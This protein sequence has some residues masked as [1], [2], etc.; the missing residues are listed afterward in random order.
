MAEKQEQCCGTCRHALPPPIRN[1]LG[2]DAT[3]RYPV[4]TN[5]LPSAYLQSWPTVMNYHGT[6]CPTY[7]AKESK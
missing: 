4:D 1:G 6:Y 7:Q 3:C 5:T 2:K